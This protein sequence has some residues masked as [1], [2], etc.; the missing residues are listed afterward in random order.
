M[1]TISKGALTVELG[2]VEQDWFP[3][4]RSGD[5]FWWVEKN[6]VVITHWPCVLQHI[7]EPGEFYVRYEI[8]NGA[9]QYRSVHPST[10][11]VRHR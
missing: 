7:C 9:I 5:T 11:R 4:A 1:T 10:L 3:G 2:C 6:G 8:G